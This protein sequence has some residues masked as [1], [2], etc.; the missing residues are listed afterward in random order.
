MARSS[1]ITDRSALDGPEAIG[2]WLRRIALMFAPL[3]V[4]SLVPFACER[5]PPL[6]GD[7]RIERLLSA[8]LT[9]L[10]PRAAAAVD[11]SYFRMGYYHAFE[12]PLC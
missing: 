2:R 1:R 4:G 7:P 3:A 12:R 6:R 9:A 11:T 10:T 8:D 5:E